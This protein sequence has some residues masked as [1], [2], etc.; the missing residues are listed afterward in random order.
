MNRLKNVSKNY[1]MN[2]NDFK[3][4]EKIMENEKIPK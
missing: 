3:N 1:K 2:D 4:S